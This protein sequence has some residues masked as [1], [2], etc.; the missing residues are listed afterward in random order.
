M[1]ILIT[2]SGGYIGSCLY[3]FL[4][5]KHKVFGVDKT[6][7]IIKSQKN[8]F[9]CNLLNFN[10]I[11]KIVEKIQPDAIIHLAAKS[12]VDFIDKKKNILRIILM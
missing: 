2:G 1:K 11:D 12:T 7:P 6:F 3:E 9:K 5:K 10:K 4:K 8:F